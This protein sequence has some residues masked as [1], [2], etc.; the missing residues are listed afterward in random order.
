MLAIILA[1]FIDGSGGVLVAFTLFFALVFSLIIVFY[2]K[3]KID[4][5][6]DCDQKMLVKGDKVSIS[7]KAKKHTIFPTPF[8]ELEVSCSDQL[9]AVDKKKYKFVIASNDR[10]EKISILFN[11]N[12]S[13]RS[14]VEVTK[15]TL[16]DFLGIIKL[17]LPVSDQNVARYEVDVLPNIPDTGTQNDILKSTVESAGAPEEDDDTS[18]T[19]IGSTGTPG[20]EHRVYIPGDPIKKINWKLS[21]KRDTYMVRLDEKLA[22]SSQAFVLDCPILPVMNSDTYVQID[23]IIEGSLAMLAMMLN[24]GLEIEYYYFKSNWKKVIIRSMADLLEL[25]E[26][27]ASFIP[28]T[29]YQRLPDDVI[30][31][32][33]GAV[34]FTTV[35]ET[36]SVLLA[37]QIYAGNITLVISANSWYTPP[38]QNVW[39]CSKDFEFRKIS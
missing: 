31:K 21:A 18:Q 39:V 32:G 5:L 10:Y 14:Y 29:P 24:Q 33:N 1:T 28:V 3:N 17:D 6:V 26:Q 11:A 15:V 37:P 22:T 4:V 12:S 8:I 16:I 38:I 20:Y 23:N 19:A 25:Q 35:T 30:K 27:L 13:G 34:C 36:N 7:V 9:E 2:M